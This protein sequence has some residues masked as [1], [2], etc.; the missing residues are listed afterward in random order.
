MNFHRCV[1][2]QSEARLT[3]FFFCVFLKKWIKISLV[4]Y[5]VYISVLNVY[6]FIYI[7]YIIN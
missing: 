4:Y 7:F 3:D 1:V 2:D 5:S 6:I